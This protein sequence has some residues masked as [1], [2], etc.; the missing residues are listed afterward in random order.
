M[1]PLSVNKNTL[2]GKQT[3]FQVSPRHDV[4]LH[5]RRDATQFLSKSNYPCRCQYLTIVAARRPTVEH[6]G[7]RPMY[8]AKARPMNPAA[9]PSASDMCKLV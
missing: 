3:G 1:Q 6:I 8:P 4:H 7:D 5:A 9:E 2:S